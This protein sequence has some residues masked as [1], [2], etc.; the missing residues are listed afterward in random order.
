[1]FELTDVT[2]TVILQNGKP[3]PILR[4]VNLNVHAG[5]RISVVGQSGTGKSTL[6]NIIGMLDLPDTGTYL[7]EGKD[8]AKMGESKRAALR[9]NSFGFVF[10][11]FNLFNARTALQNVEVPLLYSSSGKELF[12]R[13]KLAAE[14]LDRVGLGDRLQAMPGQLSGGEQQRVAIARALVRR[15][16]VILA[17]EPTGALDLETGSLVID[18]LEDVAR[19]M[20]SALIIITHD[21]QVAAR[22]QRIYQI[23]NGVL[24]ERS[25][26]QIDVALA[27]RQLGLEEA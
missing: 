12:R 21:M 14:M 1:M 2:R 16:K 15:P 6:L 5:E 20:N 27:T 26:E 22:S 9:G 11:Q 17:D 13:S 25:H 23:A 8:V 10:Q 18:L 3:L 24:H 7:F 4:G 19:D